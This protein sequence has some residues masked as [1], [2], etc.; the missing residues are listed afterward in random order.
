MLKW[1][2]AQETAIQ[3]AIVGF[4]GTILA[5]VIAGLFSLFAKKDDV[6]RFYS[7]T[8]PPSTKIEYQNNYYGIPPEKACQL[9]NNLF[10]ENFLQLQDIAREIA[11]NRVHEL[12]EETVKKILNCGIIDFNSF[13]EPDVQY[14]FYTAQK[15]YARFGTSEMLITLST[16]ISKRVEHDKDFV[17]KVT[18]DKA[19]EIAPLL[20]QAQLNFLSLLFIY[21]KTKSPKIKTL[22]DLEQLLYNDV[23][24][25]EN[26]DFGS[27]QY[28]NML[29]CLEI[30]LNNTVN[31]LADIYGFPKDEVEKICPEHIKCLSGDYTT[32]PVGIILAITN[33]EGILGTPL[34]PKKWIR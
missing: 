7:R 33:L 17:L 5:A 22:Q 21:T 24:L 25:L 30:H 4:C 1:F 26:A 9:I 11:E 16:L 27:G 23:S 29:G 3:V 14:I 13:T 32:S 8:S 28:L 12:C 6:K 34:D 31:R 15:Y 19:I 20:S 10:H 2:T 18:I